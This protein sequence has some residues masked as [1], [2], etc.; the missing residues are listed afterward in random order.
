MILP[1]TKATLRLDW[2]SSPGLRP[3]FVLRNSFQ[4]VW[5]SQSLIFKGCTS[6]S[7]RESPGTLTQQFLSMTFLSMKFGG[8][9][10]CPNK[11]PI[12][13]FQPPWITI[14][15][16]F[17]YYQSLTFPSQIEPLEFLIGKV[18]FGW[19]GVGQNIH[20]TRCTHVVCSVWYMVCSVAGSSADMIPR[21][22][23]KAAARAAAAEATLQD[24]ARSYSI[25]YRG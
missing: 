1:K 21:R 13:F 20:N 25:V 22:D 6:L 4:E 15:I 7:Y 24:L 19:M 2:R 17:N 5:P 9:L 18:L 3:N 12:T 10:T 8:T 23:C 16:F 11:N 14:I